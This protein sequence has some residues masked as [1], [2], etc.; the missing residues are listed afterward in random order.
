MF[1]N[2]KSTLILKVWVVFM[3][4]AMTTAG[5]SASINGNYLKATS[6]KVGLLINFGNKSL[7]HKRFVYNL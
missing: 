3:S 5:F 6:F 2:G 7:E 4:I 1:G